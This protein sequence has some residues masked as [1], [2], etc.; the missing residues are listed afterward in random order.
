MKIAAIIQAR[1]SS[2]IV[3]GKILKELPYASSITCLE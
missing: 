1:K 2:T 3:P